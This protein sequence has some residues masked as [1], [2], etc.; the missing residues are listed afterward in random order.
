M[1][2]GNK[3]RQLLSLARIAVLA[4]CFTLVFAAA[5]FGNSNMVA[6]AD[7]ELNKSGAVSI[8]KAYQILPKGG[9]IKASAFSFNGSGEIWSATFDYS[10]VAPQIKSRKDQNGNDTYDV[11]GNNLEVYKEDGDTII[12]ASTG[13]ANNWKWGVSN[14]IL[15][16]QVHGV[17]N[18]DLS[19]FVA[20]MI[21]ND[22]VVVKATVSADIGGADNI[23]KLFFS[24]IGVPNAEVV[25]RLAYIK[26]PKI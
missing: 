3:S 21:Q 5:L 23:N 6:N 16:A 14:A 10:N 15:G 18:F 24:A 11:A 4:L 19:G 20:K 2:N 26:S 9:E 1:R 12:Y 8:G 13:T 17:I 25:E 22:K 7:Y